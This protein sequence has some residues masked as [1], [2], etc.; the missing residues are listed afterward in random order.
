MPGGSSLVEHSGGGKPC[1]ASGDEMHNGGAKGGGGGGGGGDKGVQQQQSQGPRY[2]SEF[3]SARI[4]RHPIFADM[5][6]WRHILLQQ[7]EAKLATREK[8]AVGGGDHHSARKR[9]RGVVPAG[10]GDPHQHGV[11]LR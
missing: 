11:S 3:L 6:F 8:K 4:R 9:A 2:F 10:A 7:I 1:G 5:R